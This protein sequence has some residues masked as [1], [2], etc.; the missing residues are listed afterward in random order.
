MGKISFAQDRFIQ[1]LSDDNLSM[2]Q[3]AIKFNIDY[4]K[5][6]RFYNTGVACNDL[7]KVLCKILYLENDFLICS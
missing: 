2:R 3:F 1:Y 7:Q 6:K 4:A 5:I